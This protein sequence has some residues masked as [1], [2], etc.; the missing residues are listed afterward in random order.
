M[1]IALSLSGCASTSPAIPNIYIVSLQSSK[2]TTSDPV[3]VRIGYW[4]ICGDDGTS[5]R[6]QSSSGG[7]PDTVMTGLFPTF[8]NTNGTKAKDSK[9]AFTAD[10]VKDLVTTALDLQKQIFIS[11]LAGATFLFFLGVVCLLLYK[12]FTSKPNPDK[13]R[14]TA[15]VRRL[16]YGFLYLSV[17]LV[18]AAALATTSTADALQYASRATTNAPI[19]MHAG[20]TLQVLQWMAFGFSMLFTLSVPI[21]VRSGAA[22]IV[23]SKEV[24]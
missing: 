9:D 19:L 17:G 7:N 23:A 6:C 18:F 15:I 12:R 2:N 24:V 14:R 1:L 13:P 8:V 22:S 21:L 5:V 11:V 10:E 16:T 20:R 3:Q 4:G